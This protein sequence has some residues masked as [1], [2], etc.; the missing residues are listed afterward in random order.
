MPA[1]GIAARAADARPSPGSSASTREPRA[2]GRRRL[3]GSPAEK[4]GLKQGDVIIGFAGEKVHNLLVVPAQ[5]RDQRGRQAV[6][7]LSIIRDGKE[8]TTSIVPAP[9]EKVVFDW[10]SD[11]DRAVR[12][13]AGEPEKTA[14]SGFGLEVQPLTPELAKPLGLAGR[15]EGTGRLFGE[16]GSPAEAA[17]IQEGDVITKVIRD[18]KIQPLTS[19]KDFQDLASKSDELAVYV[20]KGKVG[21]FVRSVQER[22]VIRACRAAA[23]ARSPNVVGAAVQRASKKGAVRISRTAPFLL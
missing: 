12:T 10:S 2:S 19:V 22:E 17:G 14:I 11:G 8:R 9:S 23:A 13:E 16:G 3:P 6:R 21:G 15:S 5:G 7:D 20:Q 4:A 18:H 1:I